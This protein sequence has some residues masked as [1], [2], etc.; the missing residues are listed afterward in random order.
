MP[1]GN[2]AG[3]VEK[4]HPGY[5]RLETYALVKA[6]KHMQAVAAARLAPLGLYPGQDRLLAELWAEDG[7][8]QTELA[9]R[10]GVELPTVTKALQRLERGGLVR[11]E[12]AAHDQRQM[13]VSLTDAGH[14]VQAP[15][16]QAWQEIETQMLRG[17]SP[18]EREQVGELL[19]RM[20][21]NL[22]D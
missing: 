13:L 22:S 18:A 8:T 7:I 10:L 21:R 2:E 19:M 12:R 6:F 15:V 9:R 11:R 1:P 3:A 5:I 17:L 14:G 16:E 4:H 20:A